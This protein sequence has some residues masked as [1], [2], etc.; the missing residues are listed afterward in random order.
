MRYIECFKDIKVMQKVINLPSDIFQNIWGYM[1]SYSRKK[2]LSWSEQLVKKTPLL[3]IYENTKTPKQEEISYKE[4]YDIEVGLRK[5][6]H[7]KSNKPTKRTFKVSKHVPKTFVEHGI[8][9]E[10]VYVNTRRWEDFKRCGGCVYYKDV[11]VCDY[12]G[13]IT[14]YVVKNKFTELEIETI[15]K[16][17]EYALYDEEYEEYE[18]ESREEYYEPF[19]ERREHLLAMGF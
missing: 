1:D 6:K 3:P 18:E 4:E 9:N 10:V 13:G 5:R 15:Y 7:K 12:F 8:D 19:D 16:L 2:M 14:D 11:M 17:Y